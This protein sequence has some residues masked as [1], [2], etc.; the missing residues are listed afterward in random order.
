MYGTQVIF[1]VNNQ[2][3]SFNSL[4]VRTVEHY[5]N[6]AILPGAPRCIAGVTELRGE[7][8]PVCDLHIRFNTGMAPKPNRDIIFVNCSDGCIGCLVDTVY[9]IGAVT[10]DVQATL[11]FILQSDQTGYVDGIVRHNGELITAIHHEH[12]LTRNDAAQLSVAMKSL[13]KQKEEEAEEM[14]RLEAAKKAAEEAAKK[15]AEA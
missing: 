3:Y 1:G 15:A 2:K 14:A 13:R 6:I 11:P 7:W 10:E 4:Y 8:V 5:S 9:E 12:I